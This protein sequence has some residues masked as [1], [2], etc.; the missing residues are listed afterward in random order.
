[1]PLAR[2]KRKQKP[3]PVETLCICNFNCLWSSRQTI[4]EPVFI[5]NVPQLSFIGCAE[6]NL[7]SSLVAF[8]FFC[9]ACATNCA[10]TMRGALYKFQGLCELFF[11]ISAYFKCEW[12]IKRCFVPT[13]HLKMYC[14]RLLFYVRA[15]FFWFVA[16]FVCF[17]P[18]FHL[19]CVYCFIMWMW[20]LCVWV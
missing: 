4:N 1:M 14:C 17:C 18:V 6:T 16:R 2:R 5:L 12:V 19:P 9:P 3:R 11:R 13:D 7:L 20:R 8:S 15:F 10:L